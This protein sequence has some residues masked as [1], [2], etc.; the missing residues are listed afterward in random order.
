MNLIEKL[1]NVPE[2]TK[3]YSPLFRDPITF[4][5]MN[6]GAPYP[7]ICKTIIGEI[8]VLT[9]EGYYTKETAPQNCMLFPTPE[10]TWDGYE[11]IPEGSLVI[12]KRDNKIT[13][14]ACSKGEWCKDSCIHPYWWYDFNDGKLRDSAECLFWYDAIPTTK[15]LITINRLLIKEG[16]LFKNKKLEKIKTFKKGAI[17]VDRVGIIALFDRLNEDGAIVFQ[18]I[19]RP[20]GQIVVKTDVGI[21]YTRDVRIAA[22]EEKDLFFVSLTKAGYSWDGEKVVSVFKKGDIVASERT[23]SIVNHIADLGTAKNVIYYQ[24]CINSVGNLKMGV[25]CGVGNIK[26]NR[27]A[28]NGEKA[29]I[30]R[31]LDEAGYEFDGVNVK[32]KE[33]QFKP[34]EEVLVRDSYNEKWKTAHY[35]HR[36]GTTY[37]A[38]GTWLY[39]IPYNEETKHLR[40][41]SL[42]APKKY[43]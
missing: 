17:V 26:D 8:F 24:A 32:Y 15:E 18:A 29:R 43:K 40:G 1:K 42:D 39:C 30:L 20:S 23:I 10:M 12:C 38:G 2:G 28:T 13:Q 37:I 35:S 11:Y 22:P 34:F 25:D 41:T 16:Y 27:N 9:R 14:I 21:G 5:R 4:V 31:M 3:M 19:R 36:E 7:I 6:E 33:Y